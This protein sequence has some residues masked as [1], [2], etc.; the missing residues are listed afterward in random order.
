M[1]SIFI[2][3]WNLLQKDRFGN[4]LKLSEPFQK[5]FVNT[6]STKL[7]K[8]YRNFITTLTLFIEISNPKIFSWMKTII[9]SLLILEQPKTRQDQISKVLGMDSR[10]EK[11]LI[12]L[13]VH[14]TTC[15]HKQFTTPHHR[16]LVIFIL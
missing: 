9:L 8:P 10:K 15:L 12:I 11:S 5:V 14:Q 3:K 4:N 6:S 1:R 13:L 2:F 7:L 16:K